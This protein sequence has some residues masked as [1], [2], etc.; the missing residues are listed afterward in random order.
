MLRNSVL[1]FAVLV[2]FVGAI[3][4][5]H[6][7]GQSNHFEYCN[8]TADPVGECVQNCGEIPSCGATGGNCYIWGEEDTTPDIPA[9]APNT[10]PCAD[11]LKFWRVCARQCE[12]FCGFTVCVCPD[13]NCDD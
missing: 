4:V 13:D 2:A 12:G 7:L 5:G 1:R 6:L 8:T 11:T 9:D 10:Y 3:G